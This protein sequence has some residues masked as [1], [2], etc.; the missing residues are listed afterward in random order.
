MNKDCHVYLVS[1]QTTPNFTPALDRQTRPAAVILVV[2]PA[3][4]LQ[5]ARLKT[6]LQRNTDVEVHQFELESAWDI[7]HLQD[8]FQ[9]LISQYPDKRLI[10]NATGGTKP[11]SIA[12]YEAFRSHE[13]PI[14][15][16]HPHTDELIWLY[17]QHQPSHQLADRISIHDFIYSYG[18]EVESIGEHTLPAS[19]QHI[20]QQFITKLDEYAGPLGTLNYYA[21]TAGQNN[22][23]S[24]PVDLKNQ[25]NQAF[26]RILDT[27]QQHKLL[28]VVDERIIFP[29]ESA[30]FFAN[31]GWLEQYVYN[32]VREI[33]EKMPQIQDIAH[34]LELTRA[35][36]HIRNELDV[37][38]LANNRLKVIE[39]KTKKFDRKTG[40]EALYKLD[41]LHDTIGGLHAEAMLISYRPLRAADLKRAREMNINVIQQNQLNTL[42]PL[43]ESW[44][45][46]ETS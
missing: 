25:K 33:K 18:G 6:I 46:G 21:Y 10:L 12:A 22:L 7:T 27:L 26:N 11:M 32:C 14:F 23:E 43:L 44:I 45:R 31:G 2:T 36:T 13:L 35:G 4:Q 9:A 1:Y 37:I 38:V 19:H 42:K 39:C 41:S 20:A 17:P 15:Y 24:R 3:M 29:N 30:R 16:I 5:A 8:R 34:S 28:N 40:S